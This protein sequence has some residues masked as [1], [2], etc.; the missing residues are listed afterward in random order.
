MSYPFYRHALHPIRCTQRGVRASWIASQLAIDREGCKAVWCCHM[1]VTP[2]TPSV[3]PDREGEYIGT[4]NTQG[5]VTLPEA[6]RQVLDIHLQDKVIFR[7]VDG[8]VVIVGKLPTLAELAGSIPSLPPEQDLA[9]II[10][11]AKVDA[12]QRRLTPNLQL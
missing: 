9:A 12:Y 10:K 7:I 5:R 6:V 1:S 4:V 3:K 2:I 11:E 8:I